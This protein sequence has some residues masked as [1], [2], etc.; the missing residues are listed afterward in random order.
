MMYSSD[1][2]L[3]IIYKFSALGK[4]HKEQIWEASRVILGLK[5][6]S[7]RTFSTS[8]TVYSLSMRQNKIYGI[9]YVQFLILQYVTLRLQGV[10]FII[11]HEHVHLQVYINII[12]LE[13]HK[14]RNCIKN[15]VQ[16]CVASLVQRWIET[17]LL[18]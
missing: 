13:C 4:T 8:Y 17:F 6:E 12:G 9:F 16:L 10:S 14:M 3:T 1:Q 5:Y 7:C 11:V 2:Y 18:H 15:S